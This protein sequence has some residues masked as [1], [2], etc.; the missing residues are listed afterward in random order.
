M[1][2]SRR[3]V[4]TGIGTVAPVGNN[5]AEAWRNLLNGKSGVDYIT[6]FDPSNLAIKIAGEVK[7]FSMGDAADPKEARHFDRNV[8]FAVVAAKQAVQDAELGDLSE[9][10]SDN[11]GVIMG[12]AAGGWSTVL[13][14]QKVLDERG[15]HRVSPFFVPNCLPDSASGQ[16][17]IAVGAR[18]PNMAVVSACATGGHAIGEAM[19][20]IKRG[21]ADV[22]VAGG[23]DAVIVPLLMAGFINM[24]ALATDPEPTKASRPFDAR[25]NG[26]VLAEGATVMVVEEMERAR[27]RGAKIY[28]EVVGYG[29]TNDA[30]H[31]AA[32]LESGA[33]AA[34]TME[35]ALRKAGLSPDQVDYVNAHGTST[36]LNDRVETLAIKKVFGEHAYKLAVSST[37]SMTGHMLGA[38]GAFEAMVCALAIRDNCIPPTINYQ[39][40]DPDCDL[41]Y[42]PNEARS[43]RVDVALSNSIGLG[44]HN[45]CV[46]LQ[47]LES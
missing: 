13:A 4:I 19:E 2:D 42:V 27:R 41:D 40:P 29:S 46:V 23:T 24:R 44:G 38:A 37:K 18:G 34:R 7:H 33:G 39:V 3:V 11:F 8:Q 6:L 9:E 36:P 31:M 22:I 16:V 21:D 30:Y 15:P 5:P 25:R 17:A 45:S 26:F 28:A 1:N 20:T 12:S 35:R 32:Q 43:C 14:Q 47:R 10:E